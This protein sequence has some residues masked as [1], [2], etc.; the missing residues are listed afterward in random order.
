[1]TRRQVTSRFILV[2]VVVFSISYSQTKRIRGLHPANMDLSAK[3]CE[4][5]FQYANGS[6]LKN[7]AIPPAFSSWGSFTELSEQNNE[8]LHRILEEAA[9]TKNSQK[10]TNLQK[11][12]DFFTTGMDSARVE[13]LGSKPLAIYLQRI[14]AITDVAGVQSELAYL[15]RSGLGGVFG[16]F[17]SQDAKNSVMMIGSFTQGGLGMPDR[18]YYLSDDEKLKKNRADYVGHVTAMFQLAG[19]DLTTAAAKANSVLAFET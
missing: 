5:F 7:N 16:F 6:W 11:I 12:G 4:D 15:H 13:S 3:S 19:D 9:G 17:A 8:V 1:M 10:G 14:D 18:D 2:A